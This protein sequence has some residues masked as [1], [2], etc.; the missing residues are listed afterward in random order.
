MIRAL[1]LLAALFCAQAQAQQVTP[2]GGGGG[3]G[4]GTVTSVA[5]PVIFGVTCSVASATTVPAITCTAGTPALGTPSS[6]TLTNA[7]GLPLSTGVTGNL[8]ATNLNSGTSASSTTFWRGDATWATPSGASGANPSGTAGPA[9]VNGVATTFMRSD[10]APAVQLATSAQ[11]GIIQVD[12]QTLCVASGVGSTC[13]PTRTAASPTV[14]TTDMGGSV[15]ISSGGITFPVISAGLFDNK[16]LFFAINYGG[17][18]AAVTNSTGQT[19]NSG[20][21]CVVASGIPAGAMWQMQPN[22]TTI[23]CVQ[24]LSAVA[25]ANVSGLGTNVATA[26]GITLSAAGGLNTTIASGT[27]AMGTGAITSATCATVVTTTATNTATTDV[28]SWGFN[29]DPTAVTGYIPATAG[30][31]TII[32]YPSSGNVNFKVCNDTAG[33]VTPGAITLNWRVVR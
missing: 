8:P 33:S 15:F 23:D 29:G 4:S 6:I 7:T 2:P 31:L 13:A 10:G 16:Q 1:V 18:A 30:M 17:S 9:A 14:L 21:G 25:V 19:I 5:N 28:V 26:L 3:G 24:T 20:S 32:A 11:K 12:G 27:S 22:G